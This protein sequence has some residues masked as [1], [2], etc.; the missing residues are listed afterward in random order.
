MTRQLNRLAQGA[1]GSRVV[2]DVVRAQPAATFAA[3]LLDRVAGAGEAARPHMLYISQITFLQARRPPSPLHAHDHTPGSSS[4]HAPA[5]A[6]APP[7]SAL[8]PLGRSRY[9]PYHSPMPLPYL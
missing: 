7:C 2:I 9:L 8:L 1:E 6:P 3:R 4:T 5:P